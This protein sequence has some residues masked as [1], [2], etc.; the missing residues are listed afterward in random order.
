[1]GNCINKTSQNIV[2]KILAP[3]GEKN[4]N[5]IDL[6]HHYVGER[7]QLSRTYCIY[8]NGDKELVAFEKWFLKQSV[9]NMTASEKEKIQTS[10]PQTFPFQ[11]CYDKENDQKF[12]RSACEMHLFGVTGGF[13]DGGLAHRFGAA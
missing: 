8:C 12:I 2:A 11:I 9:K 5:K 10:V 1:M 7:A 3:L 6:Q 13:D 4:T